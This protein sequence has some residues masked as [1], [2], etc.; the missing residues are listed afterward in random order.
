MQHDEARPGEFAWGD[1]G[2]RVGSGVITVDGLDVSKS[3]G[4]MPG[5]MS[6]RGSENMSDRMP[7]DMSYIMGILY[8]YL[9]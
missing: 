7:G 3:P 2:F 5:R 6:G 4:D 8:I 9:P 1:D